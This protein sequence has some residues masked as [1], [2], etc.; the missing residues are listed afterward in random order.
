MNI[1]FL[2][3]GDD[4]LLLKVVESLFFEEVVSGI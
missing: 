1:L 3:V 2:K 4:N